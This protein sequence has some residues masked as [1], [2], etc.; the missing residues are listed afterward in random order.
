[1]QPKVLEPAASGK[2]EAPPRIPA[3]PENPIQIIDYPMA[4]P[5]RNSLDAF[6][7]SLTDWFIQCGRDLPWR[8]TTDP[9]A[10][11]VSEF[12]LQQ[13][14]VATVVDYYERWMWQFPTL[15]SL[16]EANESEVLSLWQGLGYYSRARNLH[17]LAQVVTTELAGEIPRDLAA[18]QS[19]PGI[20]E[21]T[22]AAILSFA[23]DQPA[24]V[25]DANVARVL[26]RL[27][28]HQ[29]P[30]QQASSKSFLRG[31]AWDIQD[32]RAGRLLNSAIMELG[33]LVCRS[34]QPFCL[35]CPVR[36][37]CQA[38]NPA[39]LPVKAARPSVTLKT[40]R[41][42]FIANRKG[43]WLEHSQGPH[44][45]GLWILPSSQDQEGKV[46]TS[47]SYAITRYRVE[48][49]VFRPQK[50]D[51]RQL[52]FHSWE[53]LEM[54]PMPSPHRRAVAAAQKAVHTI[55]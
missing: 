36:S 21:Y 15:Q 4:F 6:R 45:K 52:Q 54:L 19:L 27:T 41:R 24:P 2:K 37:F 50:V 51:L 16:A 30:M 22:A 26:V 8:R 40:E 1:M 3:L 35:M 42:N 46:V 31:V 53:S 44:W 49:E 28:N 23:F 14:Q 11:L 34:G 10:I 5:A 25:I 12:M 39:K 32:P 38:K 33:A 48:M 13:T 9:Y 7:K 18:L 47:L 20:G 43:I 29:A 17:R 55:E